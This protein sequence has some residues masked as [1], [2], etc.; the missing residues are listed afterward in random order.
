MLG[1]MRPTSTDLRRR[2]VRARQ[3]GWSLGRI[4][5]H[6]RLPKST[7]QHVVDHFRST[8]GLEPHPQNAGR[9]PAF[10]AAAL[11]RLEQDVLAHPDATL[12]ELRRRSGKQVSLVALHHTL[13]NKLGFT[14]KKSLYVRA[15]SGGRT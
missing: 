3:E 6:Y 2:V 1:Y 7:V 13:R 10:D 14:R 11:R 15:N 12:E 9:K 8:G 4:A 5:E